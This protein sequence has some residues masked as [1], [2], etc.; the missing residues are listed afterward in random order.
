MRTKR[1]SLRTANFLPAHI[2]EGFLS[3]LTQL[4]DK[5]AETQEPKNVYL[6]EEYLR[7][8][9]DPRTT[10]P[11]VRRAAAIRKWMDAEVSNRSTNCRLF[12]DSDDKDFGWATSLE[13]L[14]SARKLIAKVL[15]PLETATLFTKGSHTNGAST[16]IGRSP[17]AALL[18][19]VGEAHVSDKALKHWFSASAGTVLVKQELK[20]MNESV[21]F[22]VP[23]STD[24]DR[25]ACKE[26][27]INMFLQRCAG[28]HIRK[29]LRRVG[30]D[31]NDQ[32]VNQGLAKRAYFD[33]LA[34]VDLSSASDTISKQLV[35]SLLPFEWYA[36][37]DDIRVHAVLVDGESHSLEMFSSMGNG[38]TF[39][40]ES[41]IFWALTRSIARHSCKKGRVSVYG[42]DIICPSAIGPRLARV[43]S[44]LGFKVNSKKSNWSGPLRESCG[45]HYYRGL[46]VTP[47]YVREPV[48]FLS[49]II[50][51]LNRLLLWDDCGFKCLSTPEVI[52]FH[53][54][55]SNSIPEILKGGQD[56]ESD[57]AL[58]SGDFP[59]SKLLRKIRPYKFD[60]HAGFLFWLTVRETTKLPLSC[61]PGSEGQFFIAKQPPWLR[62][63]AWDPYLIEVDLLPCT[64]SLTTSALL[65]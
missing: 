61:N 47:F 33:K 53:R 65:A 39:E 49:D 46:D 63:T 17:M 24:I 34:T 16:R 52:A 23:K 20:V 41:L 14:S 25:V 38:F 42:D 13:I 7:K 60:Q 54:K 6:R 22:T 62:R 4:V 58:V 9:S 48:V 35:L 29:G 3:D 36:V 11:E 50:R 15:G 37:L 28:A 12:L 5:L 59:R 32:T 55:W 21:L 56:P 45:K 8:Y 26:P 40:L 64:D 19:H 10:S 18:K 57:S 44:W 31:L 30:I 27:E 2:G 51:L 43:F 1:K